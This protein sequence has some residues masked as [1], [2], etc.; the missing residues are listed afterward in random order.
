MFA[1]WAVC[2]KKGFFLKFLLGLEIRVGAGVG[3]RAK[4]PWQRFWSL[5]L[6]TA[7]FHFHFSFFVW[8]EEKRQIPFGYLISVVVSFAFKIQMNQSV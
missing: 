8:F 5:V 4:M 3:R 6:E 2:V 1:S 7:F